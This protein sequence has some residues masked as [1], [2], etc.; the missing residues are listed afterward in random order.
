MRTSCRSCSSQGERCSLRASV[1]LAKGQRTGGSAP[2]GH[3]S[4]A[5]CQMK[6]GLFRGKST[7]LTVRR[8]SGQS[9]GRNS[10]LAGTSLSTE[11][12]GQHSMPC[13]AARVW[14]PCSLHLKGAEGEEA[15]LCSQTRTFAIKTVETTNSVWLVQPDQ[16]GG[17]VLRT[18]LRSTSSP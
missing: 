7:A 14:L 3:G 15:V 4:L 12:A 5:N 9:P 18:T 16:V 1:A 2:C 11:A 8:W 6:L 10:W 13:P 17:G